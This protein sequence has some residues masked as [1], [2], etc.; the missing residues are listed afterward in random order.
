[1]LP[2]KLGTP[3]ASLTIRFYGELNDY[4]P[5]AKRGRSFVAEYK[6]Q[7]SL[8]RLINSICVPSSAIDLILVNGEAVG[9]DYLLQ[10]N[11]HISVYPLFRSID[12]SPLH[13]INRSAL[14]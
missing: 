2:N 7:I 11:D 8:D 4:L 10:T 14:I 9:F 6:H 12:I 3:M 13:L 1:M 5:L